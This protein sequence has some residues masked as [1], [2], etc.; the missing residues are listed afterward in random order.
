[1]I[2]SWDLW[3]TKYCIIRNVTSLQEY[4]VR[5]LLVGLRYGTWYLVVYLV[6]TSTLF[7][8]YCSTKESVD[9]HG[10]SLPPA[11]GGGCAAAGSGKVSRPSDIRPTPALAFRS[12]P[13]WAARSY[14][15]VAGAAYQLW[16]GEQ[17]VWA[18]MGSVGWSKRPVLV[19][20]DKRVSYRHVPY[21][22]FQVLQRFRS[23]IPLLTQIVQVF[24]Y[25]YHSTYMLL[26]PTMVPCLTVMLF[27]CSRFDRLNRWI[28]IWDI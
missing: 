26:I 22:R 8:W 28:A 9:G 3:S 19:L 27:F 21:E 1:M 11:C 16:K 14:R 6:L 13:S 18:T 2:P 7:T 4:V 15:T 24:L 17:D 10:S 25:R 5:Y 12:F 23:G 20:K